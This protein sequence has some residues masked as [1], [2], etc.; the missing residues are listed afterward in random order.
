[1]PNGG[2][3]HP[4][5]ISPHPGG[6]AGSR[7]PTTM[8]NSRCPLRKIRR[9]ECGGNFRWV[10]DLVWA[11]SPIQEAAPGHWVVVCG[12]PLPPRRIRVDTSNTGCA[13]Q[14]L[15]CRVE[16]APHHSKCHVCINENSY[17]NPFGAQATEK[18]KYHLGGGSNPFVRWARSSPGEAALGY[19]YS[20]SK[21][22]GTIFRLQLL[23]LDPILN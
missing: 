23:D 7:R 10:R 21:L 8:G 14:S 6:R 3:V 1:M 5:S 2:P 12:E 18:I 13:P 9:G 4:K 15:Y 20:R 17:P 16:G 22:L 19:P 11:I